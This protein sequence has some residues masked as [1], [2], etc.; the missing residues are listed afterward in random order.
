MKKATNQSTIIKM[1]LT[2]SVITVVI[3]L[4]AAMATVGANNKLDETHD[5]RFN[6]TQQFAEFAAASTYLTQESRSYAITANIPHYNNY[7]KEVNTTKRREVAVEAMNAIGLSSEEKDLIKQI[8]DISNGL[9][10]LEDEAMGAIQKNGDKE[11]ATDL[12]YGAEYQKSMDE[13]T[14]I[15]AEFND[16]IVARTNKEIEG[17]ATT[18]FSCTIATFVCLVIQI[19]VLGY[20]FFFVTRK[21]LYPVVKI[22]ENMALLAVGNISEPLDIEPDTSEIGTLVSSIQNT[23]YF[24]KD[25]IDD[26]KVSLHHLENGEFAFKIQKDY[27]GEFGEIKTAMQS[28]ASTLSHTLNQIHQV[29]EQVSGGSE[30]VSSGAQALAAGVSE[31]AAAIEQLSASIVGIRD[32]I[33]FSATNSKLASQTSQEAGVDVMESKIQM[34]QMVAAMARITTMSNEINKIIQIIDNI[35]F[36]TN[37]LALNAAVEAARAGEAGKGFAV[38][39]DEV[40]NLAQKSSEAAKN[41]GDLISDTMAAVSNGTEI[42]NK[43]AEALNIV[44]GK[45]MLVDELLK[46][47]TIAS[48]EQA[49]SAGEITIGV[50]QIS[51]V[52]QTNSATAQESAAAAEELS[53]QSIVLKQLVDDFQLIH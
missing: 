25:M 23:K 8:K 16:T 49:I 36:Q 34:E 48:D 12:L 42:T 35:A 10:P 43:T 39:A 22:Q 6:L 9:V 7:W 17:L 47:I 29:A 21:I 33:D 37:I 41:T 51:A 4:C 14:A 52:I 31:Q 20:I 27:I 30:Q 2:L 24:M 15:R 1:L 26:I 19:C 32:Q 3:T 18:V 11:K 13:M 38:V 28:I 45:A 5:T 50:D 44:A 46:K 40:R 53:S